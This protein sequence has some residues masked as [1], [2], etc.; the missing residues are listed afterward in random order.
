V[1]QTRII[2]TLVIVLSLGVMAAAVLGQGPGGAGQRGGAP[3]DPNLPQQPTAVSIPTASAEITGPGPMF[4]SSPSLPPGKGLANFKYEMKEYFVAGTANKKPYK[5]RIVVRKPSDNSKFSGL[6]LE[7]AMHPSGAAHMFEFTSIYL[8]SSGHAAVEIVTAGLEQ[9]VELN[10]ERYKDLKVDQDQVPEIL[11]QVGALLKRNSSSGPMAGLTIRKMV[12]GGTSATAGVLIRYL[13]AHMV[14]RTPEMKVIY[15][16]FMP[17]SNGSTIRQVDVPLIQ[18]PTMTEV[19]SGTVTARQDGDAPGDQFR[20]YEFAGMAHVDSRDSV[21]FKPDPCKTPISQFPLQAYFSIALNYLFD[22]VDK[23]KVPPRAD[24]IWL[25]RNTANDG[26][27]MALDEQGNAKGGIRNP[28]VDVPVSKIGVRNEAAAPPI[29]NPSQW[30]ATHGANAPAQM[31]GL[32]GYQVAFSADQLKKLYGNKKA[33]QERVKKKLD[34]LEKA[35]WSLPQYRETIL[36]DAARVE[37]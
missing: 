5:T 9:F 37:F 2:L 36:A 25:D 31:C 14:Y 34:E 13:P 6:V 30:I 1:T 19:S 29:P 15:D 16:G 21:R 12:M 22:W 28:Y 11:A 8:M 27:L 3:V 32:A 18:I 10:K 35:G 33:Y 4:D 24:R 23:G 7:E 26:S 20:V 17:T